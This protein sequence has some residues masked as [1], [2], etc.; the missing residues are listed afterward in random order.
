MNRKK[1]KRR[2]KQAARL[3][4][5]QPSRTGSGSTQANLENGAVSVQNTAYKPSIPPVSALSNGIDYDA[6]D[7]DDAYE[8]REGDELYFSDGDARL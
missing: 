7:P 5:E 2:Q 3:A 6:S 4:A 8:L 1:Q